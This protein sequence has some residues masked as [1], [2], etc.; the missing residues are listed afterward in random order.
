MRPCCTVARRQ[1][2]PVPGQSAPISA[3]EAPPAHA[4]QARTKASIPSHVSLCSDA[5]SQPA[6]YYRRPRRDSGIPVLLTVGM[7]QAPSGQTQTRHVSST[8]TN[9]S[10]SITLPTHLYISRVTSSAA[11][12]T[13]PPPAP[14]T[15]AP[16]RALTTKIS[17]L[18]PAQIRPPPRDPTPLLDLQSLPHSLSLSFGPL[19]FLPYSPL[20]PQPRF[21]STSLSRK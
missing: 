15:V 20:S 16:A 10:F 3:V 12:N 1:S 4:I 9:S 8:T 6:S 13:L 2:S 18:Q 11:H 21:D 19:D 5:A 14:A 7:G 17:S